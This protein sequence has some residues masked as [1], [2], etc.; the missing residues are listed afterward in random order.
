MKYLRQLIYKEK[1]FILAHGS[2]IFSSCSDKLITLCLWGEDGGLVWLRKPLIHDPGIKEKEEDARI[3]QSPLKT[4][5]SNLRTSHKA[6]PVNNATLVTKTSKHG[7]LR[8]GYSSNPY[9]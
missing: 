2:G 5:S 7:P 9:H 3:S 4:G 8:E 1:M 6:P